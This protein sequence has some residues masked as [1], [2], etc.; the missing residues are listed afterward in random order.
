VLTDLV[1]PGMNGAGLVGLL[2]G[3]RG[4]EWTRFL[5]MTALDEKAATEA[6]RTLGTPVLRKAFGADVLL[7][8]L[9]DGE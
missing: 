9:G 3:R 7:G 6:E 8:A 1:M 4:W 2:R 5:V